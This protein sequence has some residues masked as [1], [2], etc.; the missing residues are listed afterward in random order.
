MV[1]ELGIILEREKSLF[2]VVVG[3]V[4][5]NTFFLIFLCVS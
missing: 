5:Q 3:F 1:L 2:V 4:A